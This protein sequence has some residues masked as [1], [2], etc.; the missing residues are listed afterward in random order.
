MRCV[1]VCLQIQTGERYIAW[2]CDTAWVEDIAASIGRLLPELDYYGG[3]LVEDERTG[4]P[5]KIRPRKEEFR[6]IW[7]GC[8]L[9]NERM[10]SVTG[11]GFRPLD[12]SLRDCVESL[13]SVGE[14]KVRTKA[15]KL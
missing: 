1:C 15:A 5:D 14:V 2:S 10:K 11:L 6:A 8:T 3:T 4:H 13:I 7:A 9:R 12:E